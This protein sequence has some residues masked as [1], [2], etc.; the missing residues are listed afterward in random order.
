MNLYLVT[1][2]SAVSAEKDPGRP[3]S[4][5]GIAECSRLAGLLRRWGVRVQALAH[6]SQRRS[7]QSA[8]ILL[9]ATHPGGRLT[10]WESLDPDGPLGH[11]LKAI[12]KEKAD[13]LLV[14]HES[15]LAKIA[16]RLLVAK[17][18]PPLLSLSPGSLLWLQRQR[19]EDGKVWRLLGMFRAEWLRVWE[20]D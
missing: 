17:K 3:L 5:T 18:F 1:H 15:I 4:E 9:P 12:R 13:L 8:Q 6:S 10:H 7:R 14:G 2:G 19:T 11:V 16:T 20:R